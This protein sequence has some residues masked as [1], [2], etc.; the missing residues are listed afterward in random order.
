MVDLELAMLVLSTSAA[1]AGWLWA[2]TGSGRTPRG[3]GR[4]G[5]GSARRGGRELQGNLAEGL[6]SLRSC[7]CVWV[8]VNKTRSWRGIYVHDLIR[9]ILRVSLRATVTLESATASFL[10]KYH[11]TGGLVQW[12]SLF[13]SFPQSG[14]LNLSL[15][16]LTHYE[17]SILDQS[18]Q[19]SNL[20]LGYTHYSILHML[21]SWIVIKYYSVTHFKCIT[22]FNTLQR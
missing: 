19:R 20:A 13:L 7:D 5:E 18:G 9:I 3:L 2:Y 17:S 14:S 6:R 12:P 11:C 21:Q 22:E 4:K 15:L 16:T 10:S 1:L 8:A